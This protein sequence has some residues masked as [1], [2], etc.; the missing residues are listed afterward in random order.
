[1]LPVSP[2]VIHSELEA[3]RDILNKWIKKV[4]EDGLPNIDIPGSDEQALGNFLNELV[5]EL[6]VVSG[7][8]DTLADVIGRF[9]NP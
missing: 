3:A 1:V 5:G 7:K 8:C 6:Q 2:D 9:L 4:G